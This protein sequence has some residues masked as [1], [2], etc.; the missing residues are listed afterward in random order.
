M[1]RFFWVRVVGWDLDSRTGNPGRRSESAWIG[2]MRESQTRFLDLP[3]KVG[4]QPQGDAARKR[5]GWRAGARRSSC[6]RANCASGGISAEGTRER[7]E[8]K[9]LAWACA[10]LAGSLCFGRSGDHVGSITAGWYIGTAPFPAGL[11]GIEAGLAWVQRGYQ[12]AGECPSA[13]LLRQEDGEFCYPAGRLRSGAV[14]RPATTRSSFRGRY[15]SWSSERPAR[16][17]S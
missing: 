12:G 9:F 4:S 3:T 1:G 15:P 7:L 5:G 2:R 8:N 14:G 11:E 10:C 6:T 13:S 16:L 17:G